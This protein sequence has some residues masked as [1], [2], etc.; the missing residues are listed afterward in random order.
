MCRIPAYSK[1][2]LPKEGVKMEQ[3]KRRIVFCVA[4]DDEDD[5]MLIKEAIEEEC[6]CYSLYMVE[7][8]QALMDSLYRRGQYA[9]SP[10]P[11]LIL[12]DL[13]MPRKDGFETLREIK[14]DP[15]LAAIPVIVFSTS[16]EDQ[17][18]ERS[19]E[20]GASTFIA[21]PAT[22]E[23]LLLVIKSIS[24]YWCDIAMLPP[25]SC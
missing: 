18:I 21:K 8:G 14:S 25:K 2:F 22:Y 13:N 19:Y 10:R 11:D 20:M 1:E 17:A 6:Q 12:L 16:R 15:E 5:R 24:R 23:G 3:C 7:D 4:D 9:D